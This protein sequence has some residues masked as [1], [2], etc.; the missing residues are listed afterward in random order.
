MKEQWSSCL[1]WAAYRSVN[2]TLESKAATNAILNEHAERARTWAGQSAFKTL[3]RVIKQ[4]IRV[5]LCKPI[6][7][8]T[9]NKTG[10]RQAHTYYIGRAFI[11]QYNICG[12]DQSKTFT[13]TGRR[14]TCCHDD[15]SHVIKGSSSRVM[16]RK[17]TAFYPRVAREGKGSECVGVY[18]SQMFTDKFNDSG[19]PRLLCYNCH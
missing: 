11:Q 9:T 12:D 16:S 19:S 8:L 10:A 6:K 1:I 3:A 15:V 14:I 4:P 13:K 7:T 5:Q 2:P 18:K 17:F